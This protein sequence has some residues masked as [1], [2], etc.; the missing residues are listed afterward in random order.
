MYHIQEGFKPGGT[1]L[2]YG[3]ATREELDAIFRFNAVVFQLLKVKQL[4]H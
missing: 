3:R 1:N 4:A 2:T